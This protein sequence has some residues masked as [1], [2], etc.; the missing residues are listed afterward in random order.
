MVDIAPALRSAPDLLSVS[1]GFILAN[2][3]P[4]K[5]R[6]SR[7]IS[8]SVCMALIGKPN[9]VPTGNVSPSE[10]SNGLS[11]IVREQVTTDVS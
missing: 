4:S 9:L 2:R 6:G 7:N 5:T 1:S 11:K 8:L 3:K 10:N